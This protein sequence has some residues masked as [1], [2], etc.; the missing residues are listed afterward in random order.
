[1][2]KISLIF[3]LVLVSISFTFAQDFSGKITYKISYEGREL[4]ANEK[5]QSP[6][7]QEITYGPGMMKT[8]ILTPMGKMTSIFNSE[9]KETTILMDMM[10]Q[11]IAYTAPFDDEAK[12]KLD[13]TTKGV[14]IDKSDETKQIAGYKCTKATISK[15]DTTMEVWY[16]TDLKYAHANEMEMYKDIDGIVLEFTQPTQDEELTLKFKATQVEPMKKVKKSEFEV[17][18]DYTFMTKEQLKSMFGGGQ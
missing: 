14:K 1:M 11:K 2:R 4:E 18:S 12:K 7:G 10:G 6:T 15:G 8:V 5:A 17:P 9:T 13:E 16:T 3:A